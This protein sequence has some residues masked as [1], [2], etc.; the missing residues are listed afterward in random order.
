MKRTM[1]WIL[2]GASSL[3]CAALVQAHEMTGATEKAVAALEEQWA[4]AQSENNV[5]M[6]IPLLADK[7]ASTDTDGKVIDR[8]QAIAEQRATKY[9]SANIEDL[10]VTAFGDTAIAR[11]VITYKGTDP[12]GK[13]IDS[14]ARWTDTWVKMPGG[15]WQCVAS[16]GSPMNSPMKK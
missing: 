6:Q 16:A 3:G 5:E 2:A 13:P 7:Y 10:Q 14:H 15:K 1:A 11:V 12:K 4:K 9:S 8:A